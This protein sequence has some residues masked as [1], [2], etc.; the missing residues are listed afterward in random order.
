M[1]MFHPLVEDCRFREWYLAVYF[2]PSSEGELLSTYL[3][4]NLTRMEK[5][6]CGHPLP[7]LSVNHTGLFLHS[8]STTM[9]NSFPE[10][11]LDSPAGYLATQPGE[12]LNNGRRRIIRKLG[13]GPRSS[14]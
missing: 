6:G 11:K 2:I 5:R 14:T 10:E 3:H 7:E 9:H 13:W 1:L 12:T 8:P 4:Q